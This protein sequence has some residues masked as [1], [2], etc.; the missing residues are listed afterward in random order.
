[1]KTKFLSLFLA[2]VMLLPMIAGCAESAGETE[3]V[4][5]AVSSADGEIAAPDEDAETEMSRENTPDNLPSDLDFGGLSVPILY[6]GGVDEQEIYVE[7]LTGEVVDD[8]IYNRNVSVSERLNIE[9]QYRA[10]GS[11]TAQ[12]FPS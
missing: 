6:R 12:E 4:S 7:D 9:F 11:G 10:S 3:D 5:G 1:M 8:A 2:A